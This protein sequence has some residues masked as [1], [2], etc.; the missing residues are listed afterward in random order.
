MAFFMYVTLRG[1][2]TRSSSLPATS[3]EAC[4]YSIVGCFVTVLQKKGEQLY[5][6]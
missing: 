5:Y 4:E 1:V 6:K 2:Y 3:N